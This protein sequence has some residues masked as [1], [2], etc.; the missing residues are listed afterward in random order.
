MKTKL[1]IALF[2]TAALGL[3][4]CGRTKELERENRE[5]ARVIAELQSELARLQAE[6]DRTKLVRPEPAGAKTNLRERIK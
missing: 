1:F 2:L 3:S 6:V 5:Q 4:G